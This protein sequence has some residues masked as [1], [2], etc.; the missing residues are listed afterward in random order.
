MVSWF[1]VR[2][3]KVATGFREEAPFTFAVGYKISRGP[4]VPLSWKVVRIRKDL[5]LITKCSKSS[6]QRKLFE[7]TFASLFSGI[8]VFEF[9]HSEEYFK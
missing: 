1:R 4:M 8:W 9:S 5:G 3:I 6:F 2:N 7:R